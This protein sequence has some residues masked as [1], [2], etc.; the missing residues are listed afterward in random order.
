MSGRS[1]PE[2]CMDF[3]LARVKLFPLREK[4][5]KHLYLPAQR[6]RSETQCCP[7]IWELAHFKILLIFIIILSPWLVYPSPIHTNTTETIDAHEQ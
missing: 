7:I 4:K 3:P 1:E 6:A 5:Y 2:G